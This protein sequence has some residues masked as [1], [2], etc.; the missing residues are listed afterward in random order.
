MALQR[1][2]LVPQN[3]RPCSPVV[4]SAEHK[5]LFCRFF[6]DTHIT[7]DPAAIEWPELDEA[8]LKL[9]QSLPVWTEAMETECM[10]TCTIQSCATL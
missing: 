5:E 10:G 1:Y 6:I 7:F 3:N 9:L 2:S 8:S 4:G